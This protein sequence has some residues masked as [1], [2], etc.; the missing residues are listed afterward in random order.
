DPDFKNPKTWGIQKFYYF[1][2]IKSAVIT[3]EE[4]PGGKCLRATG[5]ISQ[6]FAVK[7]GETVTITF[8]YRSD[9]YFNAKK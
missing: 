5:R 2:D 8:F 1:K 4:A 9:D 3:D 7:A 6:E